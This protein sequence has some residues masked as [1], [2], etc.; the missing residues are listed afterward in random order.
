ML[1]ATARGRQADASAMTMIA[2]PW[3]RMQYIADRSLL[4]REIDVL[5]G[6]HGSLRSKIWRCFHGT[7]RTNYLSGL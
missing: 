2:N 1:N 5:A 4:H 3:L 7:P 6:E